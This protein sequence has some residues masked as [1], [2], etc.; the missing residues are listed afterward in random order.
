M[1]RDDKIRALFIVHFYTVLGHWQADPSHH[2]QLI[3]NVRKCDIKIR[4]KSLLKPGNENHRDISKQKVYFEGVAGV[5]LRYKKNRCPF[6]VAD[7]EKNK[8]IDC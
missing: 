6:N 8:Q 3:T 4:Q 1:K 5:Q 7:N 2:Q